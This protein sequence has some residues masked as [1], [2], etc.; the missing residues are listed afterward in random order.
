MVA[1]VFASAL[2]LAAPAVDRFDEGRAMQDLRM[3]V[4]LGPRPAGSAASRELARRIAARVPHAHFQPVFGGLRN[5]IGR[6]PGRDP[7]RTVILGAHY[8]TKNVRGFVG[9]N[10]AASGVAVLLEVARAIRP[11]TVRP[12]IVLLFFDG[13]EKPSDDGDFL[14]EGVRGSRAAVRL[15]RRRWPVVVVDMVGDRS[16]AIPREA[17]SDPALWSRIRSAALRVGAG[18]AFPAQTGTVVLDDHTP[19]QRAGFPAVDIIDF[20]FPC[21]HLTCD[22]LGAVAPR[23]LNQVGETLVSFLRAS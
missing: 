10:D 20:T 12:N 1:A 19:F 3:Q 22:D 21:W 9:A 2:A 11:K 15:F 6:I 7:R 16:L 8:D 23:S 14:T 17:N 13:E 18:S 5:V 4:A